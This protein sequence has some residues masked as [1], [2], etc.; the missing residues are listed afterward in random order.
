MP[1]SI[2][3]NIQDWFIKLRPYVTSIEDLHFNYDSAY[4][5]LVGHFKVNSLKGFGCEHLSNGIIA[6]GG[7]YL[8]LKN[9]LSKNVNHLKRISPVKNI[10]FMGL[11]GYTIRNLEVFDSISSHN[12]NGT[13]INCIDTTMTS[14]GGRLLYK[15][16]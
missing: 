6:A 15:W 16:L 5:N 7:L 3:Y 14:G 2:T 4:R 12:I 8:Y 13:L 11:D 10:G 1:K 9:N